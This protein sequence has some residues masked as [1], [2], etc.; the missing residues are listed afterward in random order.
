MHIY[1]NA[2]RPN[3][4]TKWFA[5]EEGLWWTGGDNADRLLMDGETV[6]KYTWAP[7]LP[8]MTAASASTKPCT[9][10]SS[11]PE[12]LSHDNIA[13][14]HENICNPSFLATP[15]QTHPSYP[16][17][18]QR[19]REKRMERRNVLDHFSK[20]GTFIIPEN[21]CPVEIARDGKKGLKGTVA[22]QS[23]Q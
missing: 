16:Q 1:R 2:G 11:V 8:F 13:P 18:V 14:V 3:Q 5:N 17:R 23:Q 15:G 20:G 19:K 22:G 7:P 6:S 4:V 12:R 21:L 10:F 9:S